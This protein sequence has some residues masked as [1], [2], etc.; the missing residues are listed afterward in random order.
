VSIEPFGVP[1]LQNPLAFDS[2]VGV[3]PV[4]GG[5]FEL[6]SEGFH[7]SFRDLVIARAAENSTASG[8]RYENSGSGR[9]YGLELL[10]KGR[11]GRFMGWI[12]YTLSRSE[13]R[14]AP[15]EPLRVF[16]YDQTHVLSALASFDLGRGWSLGG[17]FRYVTGLPYTPYV[18]GLV[19]LD[20]GSYTPV[21]GPRD[22]ARVSAFHALDLRIEKQWT[23]TD[24]KLAAY[25]DVRNAYNRKNSEG[26]V[27]RYDYAESQAASGIPILPVIGV[28]GEL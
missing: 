6:S 5:G 3:E 20:S 25:L 18:G 23:F 9:A 27:Y 16:Q 15:G 10:A 13:R 21:Q 28:R 17:R 19:D 7:L 11:H 24:W 8:T 26:T 2:S 12:A 22:S 1:T 14:D 4:L